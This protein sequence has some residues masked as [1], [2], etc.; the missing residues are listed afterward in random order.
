MSEEKKKGGARVAG[1]RQ[2]PTSSKTKRR[3]GAAAGGVLLVLLPFLP[4]GTLLRC[5]TAVLIGAAVYALSVILLRSEEARYLLK[6][7]RPGARQTKGN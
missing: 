5:G 3:R 7:L 2:A 1:K 6:I 4:Q